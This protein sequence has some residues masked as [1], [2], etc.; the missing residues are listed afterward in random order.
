MSTPPPVADS[1]GAARAS[2]KGMKF[3]KRKLRKPRGLVESAGATGVQAGD[4][5]GLSNLERADSESVAELVAEGKYFEA[6]VLEGVENAPEPDV[7][8]VRTKEFS[9]DDV[10]IEYLQEE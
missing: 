1:V 2:E 6:G 5:Q 10:P 3:R 8:E 4:L 9:E 7:A